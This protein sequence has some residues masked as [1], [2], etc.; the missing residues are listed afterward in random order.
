MEQD[1]AECG[2]LDR[3]MAQLGQDL[4]RFLR[5]EHPD[6]MQTGAPWRAVLDQPLP[7]EGIGIHA[8]MDEMARHLIPNG[9]AIPRPGCTAFITTGAASIGA[10]ATMAGS[11]A[12]PQRIGLTAFNFLEEL[13][14]QWLAQLFELPAGMR[15]LYSSGGSAANL[16]AL[17]AARQWAYETRG[18]DPAR[19]GLR[20]PGRLY[21]SAASHHTIHRAAAVLGLGRDAVIT[22]ESDAYGRM[23]PEAL[24]RHLELAVA[25]SSPA[26]PVA[27]VANAG[28]TSAG[29]ID[30]LRALGTLA[31]CHGLW[32]H[33][34]GAYGLPGILDPVVRPLYDG[35]ELAD[36]VVVDPHKW[37]GAPVGIGATFVRD[38]ALLNRAFTQTA[39][40][41]LEG[42]CTTEDIQHSMDSLGLPYSDLGIELSAPSR[43][44][45]VWALLR[46]IGRAGLRERIQRHNGMARHVAERAR[47]HPRLEL[48]QP[49]T[50]SICCFRYADGQGD[51]NTLNQRIHRAL[52]R[53]GHNIPS[54]TLIGKDLAIRPCFIGARTTLAHAD[55][56]VD[57]VIE[58]GDRLLAQD[59]P[60]HNAHR[61]ASARRAASPH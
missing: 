59:E 12:A 36:S 16:V 24:Q 33:V 20:Q 1:R 44:A 22:V 60:A 25:S 23:D 7:E 56:L 13:S 17:G 58:T 30:P 5:F 6:A 61:S 10:L 42:A 14:L 4:Q 48:L 57:E 8:V 32:F 51:L 40:D 45:V 35:L 46:E 34:D 54:T 3:L 28:T 41:Y 11:V 37:L 19:E 47:T 15:G 29:A 18:M 43:G 49:P 39:A 31:R 9:S 2:Q 55:A 53:T 26:V 38:R 21:A 50:L 52:V 27:V